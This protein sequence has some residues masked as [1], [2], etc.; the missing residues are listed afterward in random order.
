MIR[1]WL[2]LQPPAAPACPQAAPGRGG[3][4]GFSAVRTPRAVTLYSSKQQGAC[5]EQKETSQMAGRGAFFCGL[6]AAVVPRSL[7]L[8]RTPMST[9]PTSRP[10][11]HIST[12][13]MLSMNASPVQRV[14]HHVHE[15]S[16]H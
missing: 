13:V 9:P 4:V 6:Y 16:M 12:T 1:L 8:Q 5:P 10:R 2:V 14:L 3:P 7:C 15:G 11:S